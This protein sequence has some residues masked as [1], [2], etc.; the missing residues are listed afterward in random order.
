LAIREE[1]ITEQSFSWD[2]SS[3]IGDFR[4]NVNF[5]LSQN[6][7][8]RALAQHATQRPTCGVSLSS[9]RLEEVPRAVFGNTA[10][11]LAKLDLSCNC[12]TSL[13]E[14]IDRLDSLTYLDVSCNQLSVL[15]PQLLRLTKLQHLNVA[16]NELVELS[17]GVGF[18][19][20][21]S[22]LN[23]SSNRLREL[24]MSLACMPSLR[25]AILQDPSNPTNKFRFPSEVLEGGSLSILTHLKYCLKRTHR[26][27]VVSV[28][29][30][31]N[32]AC[33]TRLMQMLAREDGSKSASNFSSTSGY[34][35]RARKTST[36]AEMTGVLGKFH[37]RSGNFS[38]SS[39]SSDTNSSESE[40]QSTDDGLS[41]ETW[42]LRLQLNRSEPALLEHASPSSM[43]SSSNAASGPL[44]SAP[45]FGHNNNN[46]PAPDAAGVTLNDMQLE[47]WDF[48]GYELMPLFQRRGTVFVV[49][50]NVAS[51]RFSA[52]S[53]IKMIRRIPR[54][55]GTRIMLFGTYVDAALPPAKLTVAEAELDRV[56]ALFPGLVLS[57]LLLPAKVAESKSSRKLLRDL[58]TRL[59]SETWSQRPEVPASWVLF[60]RM[61]VMMG[62]VRTVPVLTWSEMVDLASCC[63][64]SGDASVIEASRFVAETGHITFSEAPGEDW[65]VLNTSWMT[66]M[67]SPLRLLHSKPEVKGL[68]SADELVQA[69]QSTCMCPTWATRPWIALLKRLKMVLPIPQLRL[70]LVPHLLATERPSDLES[71]FWPA[72]CLPDQMQYSRIFTLAEPFRDE[73]LVSQLALRLLRANWNCTCI[74]LSGLVMQLGEELLLVECNSSSTAIRMSIRAPGVSL[75]LITLIFWMTSIIEEQCH[76][77]AVVEIPC[78]HCMQLRSYDPYLFSRA[79]LEDAVASG[80]GVVLCRSVNPILIHSMAPDISMAGISAHVIE[81][82]A[83]SLG[84]LQLIG[85]GGFAKVWKGKSFFC[86]FCSRWGIVFFSRLGV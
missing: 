8:L 52:M 61:L 22:F 18:L 82:S 44:S 74:W 1:Q 69:W 31:G 37:S 23:V 51:E 72:H 47:V 29:C 15:P 20:G 53:V 71:R 2:V 41:V 46:E 7:Q 76:A 38:L 81:E 67:W 34:I 68:V 32:Q 45:S 10:Q 14:S 28:F 33:K 77:R 11:W 66:T 54:L 9:R 21:L 24:P 58:L 13:S 56:I 85:E 57:K 64:I 65:S 4:T 27:P 48:S 26:Y 42:L 79:E 40:T 16:H 75:N 86:V 80:K 84:E 35:G 17:E 6:K 70:I 73:L 43:R 3:A 83:Q 62:S 19:R 36:T 5:Y 78:I 59:L 25:E 55:E 30:I 60:G 63:G 49:C 12:L 50:V 39:Q